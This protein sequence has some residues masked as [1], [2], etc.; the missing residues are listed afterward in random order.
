[1][2]QVDAFR[3]R[4]ERI[5]DDADVLNLL[6]IDPATVDGLRTLAGHK[7]PLHARHLDIV[8]KLENLHY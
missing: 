1:M 7:T 4:Y 3:E 8:A 2:Q 5:T 6:S